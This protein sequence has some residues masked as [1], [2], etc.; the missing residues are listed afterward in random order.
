MIYKYLPYFIFKSLFG[1]RKKY[2]GEIDHNDPDWHN[3][4][5]GNLEFYHNVQKGSIGH[6]INHMGFKIIKYVDLSDKIVLEIGPGIIEYLI[7]NQTRPKR[8]Y[9]A[10]I[11]SDF[12]EMS[13]QVLHEKFNIKQVEK[14]KLKDIHVPL[15]DN[16]VDSIISFHQLEHIHKLEIYLD[17]LKRI[18]KSNGLLIGAVPT[19]GSLAWGIGR[20]LTSKRYVNK[21][22][23]F[24][25][26]K[27]ICW[28]HPNFVDHIKKSLDRRFTIIRSVKK[29]F[30]LL[31][32]DL[33]LSYS[34]IYKNIK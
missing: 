6:I 7:H 18:L 1:D 13:A 10:D 15:P 25:Y 21:N 20:I 32:L 9:L 23:N 5:K 26:D 14:I 19:E 8:Y 2:T 30:N 29:P 16:S 28:T 11:R 4:K 12:L 24:N 3:W 17:E 34:F 22:L 31:P 27:I 33:N